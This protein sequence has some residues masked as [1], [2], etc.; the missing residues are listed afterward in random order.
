MG[1]VRFSN[2]FAAIC[3]LVAVS[4]CGAP[5]ARAQAPAAPTGVSAVWTANGVDIGWQPSTGAATYRVYRGTTSGGE[6]P[7]PLAT[8]LTGLSYLDVAAVS[9]HTYYYE[10]TA[11]STSGSESARSTEVTP[12]ADQS[13]LS[14][15]GGTPD[16]I[17]ANT[18]ETALTP[19]N[20]NT[21]TFSLNFMTPITDTPNLDGI[22]SSVL[23]SG[24]NYT[25]VDGQSYCEPLIKAGVTITTGSNQGVH[26]VVFVAT[27]LGSLYAIDANGGTLLWKD[28]FIYNASGNPNPLN[29]TIPNGTTAVPGGFGTET[30]S[31]D[32]SP[33]I[34]IMGTPVIDA[35]NNVL[36]LLTNTRYVANGPSGDQS[37]PHYIFAI[38]KINLS[39]GQDTSSVFAETILGFSQPSN[40]TYT[41]V[42]GPWVYGTGDGAITVS[43][44]SVLYFNAVR[45]M[46]RPAL[47]LQDGRVF[48]AFASHGDNQPYHG[49]VLTFDA[50][51]LAADGAFC[52]SPNAPEG[53]GGIWAG[54]DCVV[55]DPQG[56]FYVMTGNGAFD[57]DVNASGFPPEGN[58]GDCFIKL[59]LDPTSTEGNQGTN[60]NGWGI[61]VVDYFSPYNNESLD[62]ADQD[63]GSGGPL[64][65]PDSA[66]NTAHPHLI[67]GTG[68]Q[69]TIYLIDRD[70]MGKYN[71][72]TDDVVQEVGIAMNGCLSTPSYFNGRLYY[73]PGYGGSGVSWALN[74]AAITTSTEQFTPDS[75]AFPGGSPYVTG[76]GTQ[77]GVV[78]MM[79]KGSGQLRAYAAS[80]LTTELWTSNLNPAHDG[81]PGGTVKFAV[82]SPVNGRVYALSNTA[83]CVYGPPIPPT[84][85]PAAPSNLTAAAANAS[86]ITL[87]WTD[88]SNNEDSFLIER[89]SDGVNF[90]QIGSVSVNTTTYSDGTLTPV[91]TYYYRVRAHNTYQVSSYS[92][93]T[94]IANATTLTVGTLQPVYLYHFDEGAGTTTA[95]SVS[96]NNGVLTGTASI[97]TWVVPGRIGNAALGFSGDGVFNQASS[98]SAV[99]VANDLSPVLGTTSSVFAWFKTTQTGNN[100]HY[101]APAITGVE[102]NAGAND[103]NWGYLNAT[104]HI[105]IYVGD[106][107]GLLSNNRVNDGNWHSVAMTRNATNGVVQLYVDGTLN[108]TGTFDLGAKTSKFYLIGALSVVAFDGTTYTGG[109]YFNGQL[110]EVRIYNQVLDA[111]DISSL[112][113]SPNAP[114]Q[115][116]GTAASGTELDLTWQNN[117]PFASGAI[118][119]QAIGSGTFAT[120]AQLSGTATTYNSVALSP[121]TQ[122][123]YRVQAIDTAGSSAYS[124]V[125]TLTTPV[126]PATPTNAIIT[127]SSTNELDLA[128]TNNATNATGYHVLRSVIGGQFVQV[129][130]L[131]ASATSYKDLGADGGDGTGPNGL[132]PG[133]EYIYHV[134]CYNIAGVSDFAGVHSATIANPPAFLVATSSTQSVVLTWVAPAYNG[135]GGDLTYD[136]YRGTTTGGESLTPIVTGLTNATYTDTALTNGQTYYYL[137]TAVDPGGISVDSN[138]AGTIPHTTFAVFQQ[139]YFPTQLN[140]PAISGPNA[141]PNHDGISNL[142]AYALDLNPLSTTPQS[143]PKPTLP[144]P[145]SPGGPQY[146]TI[147]FKRLKDPSDLTYTVEV[148]SDMENW[149]S[150]PTATTQVSATS[151]DQNYE[152]VTV[153]DNTAIGGANK[154]RFIHVKV[155][156]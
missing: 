56:Y 107:G 57:Y 50:G 5:T 102:Q 43:G 93:Y 89:S 101:M 97:P 152:Q 19:G 60:V 16:S 116:S 111:A 131:P 77:N 137:V 74:N 72:S 37:N 18:N 100:T 96:G 38:H 83:L 109:T 151:L 148:S 46:G 132:T 99:K 146:L 63:L 85:A 40:P 17:G 34:C 27:E 9:G 119:Q 145:G 12:Q 123:S 80:N 31:Q 69:G 41:F 44:S 32:V 128:W 105:G 3:A 118:V 144:A 28:S 125:L 155:V 14:Y 47:Q 108:T 88:N 115:L 49:W 2:W 142:L 24:I 70:N 92:G 95:D 66:G 73:C 149:S 35:T 15:H 71:P 59:A 67:V 98:E 150:G 39:N 121:N 55:F 52:A 4:V 113:V 1:L 126:P 122:Y 156:E 22:P 141:D 62:S 33:W 11:L 82:P 147:T 112:S 6:S 130:S 120:I 64:I 68:K 53:E 51:T 79:D 90:T 65:L 36:Y 42:S 91:T 54:G 133:T 30:N 138:E 13:I 8:G 23:N 117:S 124:N 127:L 143:L 10:V 75:F 81:L 76:N 134:Q 94:N 7:T 84:S 61:K 45:N 136:V 86:T 114:S 106:A 139:L 129:A 26:D 110:D 58:Y 135:N 20:V 154:V 48:A 87:N 104:G 29:P 25:A 153:R 140:N 21:S 103:I 78:W